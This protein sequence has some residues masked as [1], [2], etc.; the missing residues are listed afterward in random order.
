MEKK[1]NRK[2]THLGR[3]RLVF[4]KAL[5]EY[6]KGREGRELT[7]LSS[8]VICEHGLKI[9]PFAPKNRQVPAGACYAVYNL[10]GFPS[11]TIQ[12]HQGDVVWASV[13][14][15]VWVNGYG[16]HFKFLSVSWESLYIGISFIC[17]HPKSIEFYVYYYLNL[18]F[19]ASSKKRKSF[20]SV[21]ICIVIGSPSSRD[22]N[23]SVGVFAQ[24]SKYRCLNEKNKFSS[25]K[26]CK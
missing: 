14:V 23:M 1:T 21:M 19:R 2:V 22:Q 6:A 25:L 17:T 11:S 24:P 7:L 4:H 5:R 13:A 16:W 3:R 12:L 9:L 26:G 15:V 10:L 20:D 18:Q 8:P